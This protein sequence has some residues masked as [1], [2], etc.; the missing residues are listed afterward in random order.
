MVQ[1]DQDPGA[2]ATIVRNV[3]K[4]LDPRMP[5]MQMTTLEEHTR[6]ALYEPHLAAVV[7]GNLGAAG[8]V[9]SFA[10]LYGVVAWVVARRTREIGV[11]MALG[12]RPADILRAV[13][14]RAFGLALAGVLAGTVIALLVTQALSG[15]IYG[16]SPLDPLSYV[17]TAALLM[18]VSAVASWW[19]ARRA[20]QVDPVHALRAE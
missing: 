15:S 10:G 12:A 9:L 7:V 16:V 8:L 4:Q 1:T 19:P 13:L 5:T 3:I 17:S 11:R 2:A 6:Y 14:T 18:I 20:M